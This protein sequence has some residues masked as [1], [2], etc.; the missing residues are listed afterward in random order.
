MGIEG[1]E[2]AAVLVKD[3]GLS[4]AVC[5]PDEERLSPEAGI[6]RKMDMHDIAVLY[7]P[8]KSHVGLYSDQKL[9]KPGPVLHGSDIGEIDHPVKTGIVQVIDNSGDSSMDA[10]IR[11]DH[12]NVN[13]AIHCTSQL[14]TPQRISI[15]G[16]EGI[17]EK[18]HR[19]MEPVS[20]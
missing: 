5:L 13:F 7:R 10:S 17:I 18:N 20:L 6:G 2:I 15:A 8:A 16:D 1:A 11:A 14:T 4:H 9:A 12:E 19:E 3:D